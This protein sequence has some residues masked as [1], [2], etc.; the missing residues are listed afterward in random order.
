MTRADAVKEQY[1]LEMATRPVEMQFRKAEEEHK[2]T[3]FELKNKEETLK[4]NTELSVISAKIHALERYE[5]AG[6]IKLTPKVKFMEATHI[7]RGQM[8]LS[9]PSPAHTS[10]PPSV[11]P[12]LLIHLLHPQCA[13]SCSYIYST[14]S[15]PS[16]AHTSTPPSVCPL[17]LIHLLHI[18]L[19]I[20]HRAVMAI[21]LRQVVT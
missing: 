8:A 20:W 5:E 13:L 21:S 4:L 7:T 16:H 6:E 9:V 1:E 10:T 18:Q 19:D 14:L 11:C 15:V 17:M 3:L 2:L 12:L